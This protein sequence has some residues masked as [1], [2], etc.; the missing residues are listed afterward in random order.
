MA[1]TTHRTALLC[2]THSILS[3]SGIMATGSRQK[4]RSAIASTMSEDGVCVSNVPRPPPVETTQPQEGS[5]LSVEG[6]IVAAIHRLGTTRDAAV[7]HLKKIE[8][9]VIEMIRETHTDEYRQHKLDVTHFHEKKI[10]DMDDFAV[11]IQANMKEQFTELVDEKKKELSEALKAKHKSKKVKTN[12]S[13]LKPT[14]SDTT[15]T[16]YPS[17]HTENSIQRRKQLKITMKKKK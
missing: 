11:R 6:R 4:A 2:I 14:T 9:D 16:R 3:Q 13:K 5:R 17:K 8:L 1:A 10:T 15:A 12:K 7:A